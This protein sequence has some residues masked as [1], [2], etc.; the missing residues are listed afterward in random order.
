M[1]DQ[2]E[3]MICDIGENYFRKSNVYDTLYSDND[4]S[5]YMCV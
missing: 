1:D 4:E 5:L 3:D 2:L